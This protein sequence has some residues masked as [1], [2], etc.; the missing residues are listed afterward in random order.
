MMGMWNLSILHAKLHPND[1][2]VKLAIFARGAGSR[3]AR[4]QM[5]SRSLPAA[6]ARFPHYPFIIVGGMGRS[7]M[8][9][10]SP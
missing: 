9:K 7:P 3:P 6:Q 5:L 10:K 8:F 4:K 2:T 1:E